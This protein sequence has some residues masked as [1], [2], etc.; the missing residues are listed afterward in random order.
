M[1]EPPIPTWSVL[2]SPVV[3]KFEVAAA[4]NM[5]TTFNA[6]GSLALGSLLQ[7]MA[8]KLDFAVDEE[9]KRMRD[10]DHDQT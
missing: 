8:D 1:T 2:V 4:F 3:R 10:A 9:L 6:K 7:T 5:E